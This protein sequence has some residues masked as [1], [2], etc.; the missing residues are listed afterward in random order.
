MKN[1]FHDFDNWRVSRYVFQ[2]TIEIPESGEQTTES[3]EKKAQKEKRV[4]ENADTIQLHKEASTIVEA[5]QKL[6][7]KNQTKLLNTVLNKIKGVG[8]GLHAEVADWT[9]EFPFMLAGDEIQ[10]DMKNKPIFNGIFKGDWIDTNLRDLTLF[11]KDKIDPNA[12]GFDSMA[13]VVEFL[14]EKDNRKEMKAKL[15][16]GG[17]FTPPA[18]PP[19]P[20]P[21]S[22]PTEEQPQ[23]PAKIETA[24]ETTETEVTAP[25]E[26]VRGTEGLPIGEDIWKTKAQN[27]RAGEI[28]KQTYKVHEVSY[29]DTAG[30]VV[31]GII[32]GNKDLGL[33]F[34]YNLPVD[35][36]S[37]RLGDKPTPT[38]LGDTNLIYPGQR[39]WI[40][41]GKIIIAD[42]GPE[43]AAKPKPEP[44]VEKP[45]VIE[46]PLEILTD[47]GEP[48]TTTEKLAKIRSDVDVR[49]LEPGENL[50]EER[51]EAIR[52]EEAVLSDSKNLE[53]LTEEQ[54]RGDRKD[55]LK[56]KK[57]WDDEIGET[58][59][60]MKVLNTNKGEKPTISPIFDRIIPGEF[61]KDGLKIFMRIDTPADG[62]TKTPGQS[63]EE[64]D[65]YINNLKHTVHISFDPDALKKIDSEFRF[66]GDSG[67]DNE[68]LF[69]IDHTAVFA[70]VNLDNP[71]ATKK[72]VEIFLEEHSAAVRSE[73]WLQSIN[74]I[75]EKKRLDKPETNRLQSNCVERFLESKGVDFSEL[76]IDE[77]EIGKKLK[78]TPHGFEFGLDVAGLDWGFGENDPKIKIERVDGELG[79]AKMTIEGYGVNFNAMNLSSSTI[80]ERINKARTGGNYEIRDKYQKNLMDIFEKGRLDALVKLSKEDQE[81]ETEEL[82]LAKRFVKNLKD[83]IKNDYS[84][85]VVPGANFQ[86]GIKDAIA[87]GKKYKNNIVGLSGWGI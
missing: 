84:T 62:I 71:A 73:I 37:T 33:K 6:I 56:L 87:G 45:P 8:Q 82:T 83:E 43:K 86:Q 75:S 47:E 38:V 72:A 22:T 53:D 60:D 78:V 74:N 27:E 51:K 81:D 26:A 7:E 25:G 59:V 44:V 65:N 50:E 12:L 24:A 76:D 10:L 13:E 16:A 18:P 68:Y 58:R 69:K 79:Q 34:S 70:G 17:S 20:Q 29:G 14:N 85:I 30:S 19:A 4:C 57:S 48:A 35:Y 41:E 61:L 28:A 54:I 77:A 80:S 64:Y 55:A 3:N 1:L 15:E 31:S 23:S 52:A 46:K 36:Q 32:K 66:L 40:E 2:G 39:I 63:Q 21:P 67:L 11:T 9:E 42:G 5:P 49:D